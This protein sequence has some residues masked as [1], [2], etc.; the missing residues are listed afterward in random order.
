MSY[1]QRSKIQQIQE[2][3]D[4]TKHQYDHPIVQIKIYQ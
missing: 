1:A 4:Q 2:L 3:G